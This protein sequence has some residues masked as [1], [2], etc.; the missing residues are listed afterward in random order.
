MEFIKE[1]IKDV[2]DSEPSGIKHED[3]EEQTGWCPFLILHCC[4]GRCEFLS[5]IWMINDRETIITF[6]SCQTNFNYVNK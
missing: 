6:N 5:S 1:E 4:F 3:T 2:S